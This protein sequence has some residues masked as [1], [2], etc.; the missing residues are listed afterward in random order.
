MS[1]QRG[2]FRFCLRALSTCRCV[3]VSVC[4]CVNWVFL[5]LSC[6]YISFFLIFFFPFLIYIYQLCLETYVYP[7]FPRKL[8]YPPLQKKKPKKTI[9]KKHKKT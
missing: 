7:H 2:V 9:T 1:L 8:F 3:G 5:Y 4:R 6:L